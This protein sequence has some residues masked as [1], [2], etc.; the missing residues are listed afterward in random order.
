MANLGEVP[1]GRYYGSIDSTPLFLMLTGRY[2]EY[3]GDLKFLE[4][5]RPH[6]DLAL[7]WIDR[8]TQIS[9]TS[10]SVT[11]ALEHWHSALGPANARLKDA[12]AA[13]APLPSPAKARYVGFATL[14]HRAFA[15]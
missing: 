14:R 9:S 12:M 3:T 1:F 6:I 11:P 15:A 8:P 2:F 13:H 10:D 7:E 4:H 5:L